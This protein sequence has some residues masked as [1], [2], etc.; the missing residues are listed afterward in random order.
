MLKEEKAILP[1]LFLISNSPTQVQGR[2]HVYN[3]KLVD[4]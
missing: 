1:G 4:T 3:H 2:K